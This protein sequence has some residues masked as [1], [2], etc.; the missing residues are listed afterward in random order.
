MGGQI[1]ARLFYPRIY[2]NGVNLIF[3]F[4]NEGKNFA[5]PL[6]KFEPRVA[7]PAA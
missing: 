3:L 6:L 4:L 1:H 5:L 2:N 7:Q